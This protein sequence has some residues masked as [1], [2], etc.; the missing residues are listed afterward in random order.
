MESLLF[1]AI[2]GFIYFTLRENNNIDNDDGSIESI[3]DKIITKKYKM[4]QNCSIDK[5]DK[6]EFVDL[7]REFK[8]ICTDFVVKHFFGKNEN[9]YNFIKIVN[10]KFVN[11]I[12]LYIQKK[13]LK[14]NDIIFLYKGGNILRF[15]ANEFLLSLPNKSSKI[16]DDFYSNFFKRSDADFSIYIKDRKSNV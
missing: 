7:D 14:K 5:L 13:N 1:S 6:E 9:I 4:V 2:G 16:L 8:N 11:T 15:V 3:I 12:Q 10:N